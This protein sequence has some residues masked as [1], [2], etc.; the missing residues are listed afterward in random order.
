MFYETVELLIET[1]TIQDMP[2]FVLDIFDKDTMS[3][4]FV[5]RCLIPLKD[6]K[7][8]LNDDVPEPKWH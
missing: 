7:Y 3:D 4:E 6:A 1:A 5:T 8:S 2:P